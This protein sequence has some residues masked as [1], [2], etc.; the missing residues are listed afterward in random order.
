MSRARSVPVP[1]PVPSAFQGEIRHPDLWLWDS[2]TVGTGDSVD[3]YCL[4]LSRR[5]ADGA[6][7]APCER[8]RFDFHVRRFRTADEGRSW[9]D[10]GAVIGP[11]EQGDGAFARNVWSGSALDLPDGRRIHALTG[12][13]E[14][15]PGRSF[16]QTL[17]LAVASSA[18]D[19]PKPAAAALL[20]PDRD[21]DRIRAA[22]YYLGNRSSLG[23]DDGEEA[24]PILAWRDPF[25]F[26]APNGGIEM[27]WSAKIGARTPAI[28]RATLVERGGAWL[29]D[30]LHPPT[31]L[32]DAAQMTQAEVPKIYRDE[33]RGRLYLLVSAGDRLHEGQPDHEVSKRLQ[34]YVADSLAGPWRPWREEGGG[35]PGF[36]YVF[37][38]SVLKADF[39]AGVLTLVGPITEQAE[40]ARQLTIGPVQTLTVADA[41]QPVR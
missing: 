29:L 32:P 4:A 36:E 14:A 7:I 30:A 31:E 8:N 40:P 9:T 24:G 2:W 37:G 26:E 38:A 16:V 10:K 15:G 11:A 6:P 25:L 17:F 41:R 22:G 23:A 19:A 27:V 33:R 28:G 13:R 5:T 34:L 39:E 35:L 20:C 1:P 21:Y 3:L 18:E 12:V